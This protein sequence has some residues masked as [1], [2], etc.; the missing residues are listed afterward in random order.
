LDVLATDKGFDKTGVIF[1]H[2]FGAF[3][4]IPHHP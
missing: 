4:C 1:F 3:C 2:Q